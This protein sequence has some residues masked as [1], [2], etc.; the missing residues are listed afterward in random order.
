[1]SVFIGYFWRWL[2][3]TSVFVC[4]HRPTHRKVPAEPSGSPP[5]TDRWSTVIGDKKPS[6]PAPQGSQE[7]IQAIQLCSVTSGPMWTWQ[8]DLITV[9]GMY[10][11]SRCR[12]DSTPTDANDEYMS[13]YVL[14]V[15]DEIC[16]PIIQVSCHRSTTCA[17]YTQSGL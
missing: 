15:V 2:T 3:T 6:A 8:R 17:V 16:I 1:M 10:V 11:H 4:E 13:E 12:A 7:V 9:L 5:G 14:F